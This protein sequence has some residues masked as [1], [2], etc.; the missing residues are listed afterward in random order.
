MTNYD[1]TLYKDSVKLPCS[2]RIASF[3]TIHNIVNVYQKYYSNGMVQKHALLSKTFTDEN[4]VKD[5]CEEIKISY[6]KLFDDST[7]LKCERY[8]DIAGNFKGYNFVYKY[9][10]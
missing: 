3:R 8:S 7:N 6:A 2:C 9:Y 1:I 10:N 5:M 4:D